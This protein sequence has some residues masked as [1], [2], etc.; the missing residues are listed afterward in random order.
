VDARIA[1]EPG[2]AVGLRP[3]MLALRNLPADQ[4]AQAAAA[5]V[6]EVVADR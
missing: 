1:R 4:R 2:W 3:R 6:S 5:L